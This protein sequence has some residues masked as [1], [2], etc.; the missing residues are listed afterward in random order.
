MTAYPFSFL[1]QEFKAN[2]VLITGGNQGHGAATV[3]RFQMS[4]R[5][6][7]GTARTSPRK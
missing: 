4:R 2:R 1:P 3:Q 7:C 5:V 6:G